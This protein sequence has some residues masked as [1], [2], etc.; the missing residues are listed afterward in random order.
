[1]SPKP[2]SRQA[3]EKKFD[4]PPRQEEASRSSYPS[5]ALLKWYTGLRNWLYAHEDST[6]RPFVFS[7]WMFRA[8]GRAVCRLPGNWSSTCV[9]IHF[10]TSL[11]HPNTWYVEKVGVLL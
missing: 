3:T 11:A 10:S 5:K 9:V 7:F 2:T 8:A 1:M 6:V 4:P